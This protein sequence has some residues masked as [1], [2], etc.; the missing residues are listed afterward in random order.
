MRLSQISASAI[1]AGAVFALAACGGHGVVPPSSAPL[2]PSAMT[3]TSPLAFGDDVS[4]LLTTCDTSPP[5][6]QWIF[7]GACDT[8]TLKPSGGSFTLAKYERISVTGLIGKNSLKT[9]VKVTIADAI[10]KNGDIK[11]SGGKAFPA[12][13]A[14]GTT[15]VYAAV[16]NQSKDVITPK[17]VKGKPVLQYTITEAK[18]FPKGTNFCSTALLEAGAHGSLVW[19]PLPG[20]G[21]IKGKSVTISA[22]TAPKGFELPPKGTALYFAINCYKQ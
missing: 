5:Q 3:Q 17:P 22:F 19:T 12:Y 18:S 14:S 2:A 13:K 6:Y 16:N 20:G 1:V 7:K 10:D 4:P 21:S 8:F 11:K 15:I 9:S